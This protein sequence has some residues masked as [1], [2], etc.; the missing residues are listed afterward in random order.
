[1][2][3]LA[4]AHSR[5]DAQIGP[6]GRI[7]GVL[8]KPV[9]TFEDIARSPNFLLPLIVVTFV[10]L[11]TGLVLKEKVN[12][13]E[14]ARR[15]AARDA[16]FSQLPQAQQNEIVGQR[17]EQARKYTWIVLAAEVPLLEL[18]SAFFYW[19]AFNAI[20]GAKIGFKGSFAVL[21]YA[22]VAYAVGFV[23]L[24]IFLAPR[25]A[26]S[27]ADPTLVRTGLSAYLPVGTAHWLENLAQSVELF[28]FWTMILTAIGFAAAVA[29]K[30]SKR[31]AW[32]MV[33]GL[34]LVFVAAKVG[35]ALLFG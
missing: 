15:A 27:F 5:P 31:A 35:W 23:I 9:A 34:W 11:V 12:W 7:I 24:C 17:A 26:G 4:E 19:L 20:L 6:A 21:C 33:F 3:S 29:G 10:A 1:M 22:Y 13:S 2:A 25:P 18:A 28:W 16:V 30:L 32:G 14:M 8:I